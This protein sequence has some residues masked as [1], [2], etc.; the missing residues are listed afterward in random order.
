MS[1]EHNIRKDPKWINIYDFNI[2]LFKE[3]IADFYDTYKVFIKNF[4]EITGIQIYYSEIRTEELLNSCADDLYR[5]A[6]YHPVELDANNGGHKIAQPI[7]ASYLIKWIMIFRPLILDCYTSMQNNNGDN[8]Q[9][10]KTVDFYRKSNE[11]F[12]VFIASYALNMRKKVTESEIIP[13]TDF[14]TGHGEYEDFIYSLRYRTHH[15]DVYRA[16]FRRIDSCY[17][18]SHRADACTSSCH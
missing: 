16:L 3:T 8:Q 11:Y 9:D 7:R 4:E 17:T 5:Y 15:Q 10:E 6:I 14:L 13:I 18:K 1:D 2:E 12:A